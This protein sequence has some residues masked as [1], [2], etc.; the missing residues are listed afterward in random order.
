MAVPSLHAMLM[1]MHAMPVWDNAGRQY[2]P[3]FDYD[4]KNVSHYA[5]AEDA[6]TVNILNLRGERHA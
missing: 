5:L 6:A 4:W 2:Y 1:R 3:V